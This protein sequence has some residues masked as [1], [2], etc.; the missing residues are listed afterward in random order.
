MHVLN[1][2]SSGGARVL[3]Q[4]GMR[5]LLGSHSGVFTNQSTG[6]AKKFFHVDVNFLT[7]LF[8]SFL[9]F[10]AAVAAVSS[11]AS[12]ATRTTRGAVLVGMGARGARR[13]PATPGSATV[14]KGR[15]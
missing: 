11:P 13:P 2:R 9:L 14:Q 4:R 3:T 1:F 8:Y 5:I 15:V 12:P 10:F 7:T 6:A